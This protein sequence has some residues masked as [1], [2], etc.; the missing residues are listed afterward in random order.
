MDFARDVVEIGDAVREHFLQGDFVHGVE[1]I[2]RLIEPKLILSA[3]QRLLKAVGDDGQIPKQRHG[4]RLPAAG[5]TGELPHPRGARVRR[6]EWKRM[7]IT[8]LYDGQCRLCRLSRDTIRRMAP[9]QR[10]QFRDIHDPRVE[11]EHPW[12]APEALRSQ[13]HVIDHSGRTLGGYLAMVELLATTT[14]GT[15]IAPLLR[16][17]LIRPAGQWAYQFIAR[18]RYRLFGKVECEAGCALPKPKQF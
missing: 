6:I 17:R 3:L 5:S 15:L 14:P 16:S 10:V 1:P 9:A 18:H 12:I 8:V 13:M 11:A 2:N 4:G 7:K